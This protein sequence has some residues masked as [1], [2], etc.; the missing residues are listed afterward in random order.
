MRALEFLLNCRLVRLLGFVQVLSKVVPRA[1][2]VVPEGPKSEEDVEQLVIPT[3]PN[4]NQP[5]DIHHH[6]AQIEQAGYGRQGINTPQLPVGGQRT[7]VPPRQ[8]NSIQIPDFLN[9]N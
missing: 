5:A 8:D 7:P 2:P 9:K 6:K 4:Y 3:G 1:Q